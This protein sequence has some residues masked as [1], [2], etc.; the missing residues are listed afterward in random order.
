M[1]PIL[2]PIAAAAIATIAGVQYARRRHDDVQARSAW[3]RLAAAAEPAPGSFDPAAVANLP[4]PAQRC[5]L[6]FRV[7]AGNL[8]GTPDYFPFHRA[9]VHAT[10]MHAGE[11]P[12]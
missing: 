8:L 5:F 10:L 1:L 6:P 7:D 12:A 4:E 2:P 3:R 9:G 11:T